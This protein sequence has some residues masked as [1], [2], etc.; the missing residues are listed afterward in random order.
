[1]ILAI[2]ANLS[3][4][5]KSLAEPVRHSQAILL[6]LLMLLSAFSQ[7]AKAQFEQDT[8]SNFDPANPSHLII[9]YEQASQSLQTIRNKLRT[10]FNISS[11]KSEY[12]QVKPRI[13][14]YGRI[15]ERNLQDASPSRLND[16]IS[17]FERQIN[18][19]EG[20]QKNLVDISKDLSNYK[21][22]LHKHMDRLTPDQ[23]ELDDFG[24]KYFE[25]RHLPLIN[26]ADSL[27]ELV[28]NKLQEVLELESDISQDH[29]VLFN[30]VQD[31]K[32]YSAK[33]WENML[34]REEVNWN[35]SEMDKPLFSSGEAQLSNTTWRIYDFFKVNVSRIFLLILLFI[36]V[37]FLLKHFHKQDLN[38]PEDQRHTRVYEYPI[39]FSLLLGGALFPQIFPPTT[40]LMYDFALLVS[41]IPFLYILRKN[42][43]GKDYRKYIVFFGFLLL[44]K[45]Q[46]IF[47][48]SSG[49]YALTMILCGLAF[50][51]TIHQQTLRKY[52]GVRWKWLKIFSWIL[53]ATI[54]VGIICILLQRV[55]LGGVLINGAGETTALGLILLYFAN[56]SDH[57]ISFLRQLPFFRNMGSNR[58][59]VNEFWLTWSNRLYILLVIVLLITFLIN[60]SLYTTVK[61]SF[62]EFLNSPR[63]IGDLTFTYG[64]IALFVLV[65]YLSS[66]LSST[67]KF[68]AEDKSYFKNRKETANIA[69]ISRFFLITAGFIIALLVSGIPIDRIT[70]ILGALSVGIGFGLQ[71]IVNNLISGIIL[72][73]E[74]PIQ[75]GDLVE[76]QQYT[77][78]IKDIGIR[79]SVIRTYD[80]AEVIVPNGNLVSQEVINWTLSNRER[81][82]EMR[83]GVAYGS[84][85][86]KVIEIITEVLKAHEKVENY[87][88]PA[89]LLDGFGDSSI[90]FRC[91][92][93]T[94]DIDNWLRIKSQLSTSIY[95]A[96]NEAGIS[97]PFPQ[98]DV[99]VVSWEAKS[100]PEQNLPAETDS[101]PS[102][103]DSNNDPDNPGSKPT[104]S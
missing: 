61:D 18:S 60:F 17:I 36:G 79:S 87:P 16:M 89:V 81:R 24:K 42:I 9:A 5:N 93:W 96:L 83:V 101:P 46:S 25:T 3:I 68:L 27:N 72:I 66:K 63:I 21:I 95:N 14:V 12:L 31:L 50:L 40:S 58:E 20:W 41:Y 51:Y 13:E 94:T 77:G 32:E 71:N 49:F 91:L 78:F 75:T 2:K 45:V 64:G 55:R 43:P 100:V 56:W 6:L 88:A 92:I 52:F 98:R 85:V 86:E 82:V 15:G 19:I 54:A 84:E 23:K 59:R 103:D 26:E 69:V 28:D 48:G 8:I 90:D 65:L 39:A 62:L 7:P 80:G 104:T 33:Y 38:N 4:L 76:L 29:A 44:L 1:M 34:R 74:R 99:H 67:I 53:S 30:R 11:I 10:G 70:I 73:F 97:I 47:S 35:L 57:L 37:Y 22:E 102:E